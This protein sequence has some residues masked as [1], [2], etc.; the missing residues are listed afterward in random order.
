MNDAV[1]FR[2]SI[3]QNCGREA[4]L[5]AGLRDS[6]NIPTLFPFAATKV[7]D[8]FALSQQ[9]PQYCP[10]LCHACEGRC[11]FAQI[12]AYVVRWFSL[13]QEL[14]HELVYDGINADVM[15]ASRT[16]VRA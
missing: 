12:N 11:I 10:L 3:P 7:G 14:F 9:A 1:F 4:R 6:V 2:S 13:L 15:H 5:D 16:Q 8:P